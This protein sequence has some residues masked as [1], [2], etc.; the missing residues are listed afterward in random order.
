MRL[1]G[2][3]A[4]KR[5]AEPV[6][7]PLRSSAGGSER[8]IGLGCM[9]LS[10]AADRD[11]F[12]GVAVIHAALD[13]G[14]TLLDTADSYAP[15]DTEIGH[16][17]RLIAEALR[18]WGGD[19]ST[20]E[21][22]T[23][24]GLVRP[25]GAW[26]PD[27][28]AKHLR[29]ACDAS[30]RALGA[31][32]IDLYQLHVVDPRAPFAT[33][34]RAL[35][36]LR[37]AG[38]VR[39]IGLCN[40]NVAQI[41]AARRIVEISCVQVG[42]SVLDDQNLRSGVVEYCRDHGIRVIA[43]R[44]LGGSRAARLA[45]DPLLVEVAERS[46]ATPHEIALAWLAGLAPDLVPIP[47]ATR[48]ETA[49]SIRR[50]REVLLAE[51]DRVRLDARFSAERLRIPRQ[52]RRPSASPGGGEVV[53]VMGMPGAGKSTVARGLEARG[54]ERL[55]RDLRGGT[56]SALVGEL[57]RGLAAGRTR[58]VLDN[59]YP[60][61]RSRSEVI[62]CAWKHGS[63]VRCIWVDAT[64]ADA[65]INAIGRLLDAHGRL[66]M[67]E[68]LRE[69]GKHDPRY[70]GPDAQFRYQRAVEP[71]TDDEGFAAIERRPF[72]RDEGPQA[73]KRAVILEY[74]EVLVLTPPG[75]APEL[76]PA[77]VTISDD[78][79]ERLERYASEGWLLFAHAWRPQ[80][81]AGATS[82]EHVERCFDRTRELLGLDIG[83]RC[84][85]HPPGPPI[86]WCR[87]PI[88]GLVLEFARDSGVALASS[89]AIGRAPADRTMA[90]RLGAAYRDARELF[91]APA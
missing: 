12:H 82:R 28:R 34:V 67:P 7:G 63:P 20:V 33:S 46:G 60:S 9:R 70:F 62:E 11:D 4:E 68:E 40:V 6:S 35:A 79:R 72:V 32:V 37:E 13:A 57:D 25:G 24:G 38:K 53:L 45:R 41:E 74:D 86:C 43:Y 16:N 84:C 59:T 73:G 90:L 71:P 14:A 54:Y 48:L 58:W 27:G 15:D 21:V 8:R 77:R 23:K 56:L 31:D 80:V 66:P 61:R 64:V 47:G 22:A 83:L 17:E 76:D 51:D 36:A 87:K 30:L 1:L 3:A 65:Q 42:L 81:A 26:V 18:T 88:P 39:R 55:N 78:R 19:R 2:D 44:P 69:R 49:R 75:G 89:L 5:R 50:A 52:S 85:P 10:T 29:A 91:G